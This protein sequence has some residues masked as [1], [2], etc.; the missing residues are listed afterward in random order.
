MSALPNKFSPLFLIVVPRC[1][2]YETWCRKLWVL[3]VSQFI[4]TFSDF[5]CLHFHYLSDAFI[6]SDLR[7]FC[8]S[9]MVES[10][11]SGV[12]LLL[13]L[14]FLFRSPGQCESQHSITRTD[15]N[16]DLYL[17]LHSGQQSHLHVVQEWMACQTHQIQ[18]ALPG[19]RKLWGCSPVL[20]CF[21][22]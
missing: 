1:S 18:Q 19:V 17:H 22:R 9:Q 12:L 8:V 14:V 16:T 15:R 20:L 10:V 4:L 2:M 7:I 3:L 6:Q 21:R 11:V 13:M 5:F